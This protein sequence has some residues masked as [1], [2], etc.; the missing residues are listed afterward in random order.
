MKVEEQKYNYMPIRYYFFI[1]IYDI[2]K[3]SIED[4]DYKQKICKYGNKSIFI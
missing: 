2:D 1:L 4:R 3:V